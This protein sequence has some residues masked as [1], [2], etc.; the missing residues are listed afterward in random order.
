M[1]EIKKYMMEFMSAKTNKEKYDPLADY[2]KKY[3]KDFTRFKY[4]FIDDLPPQRLM[5]GDKNYYIHKCRGNYFVGVATLIDV[6]LRKGAITNPDT[7]KAA[8]DYKSYVR[9][10]DFSVFSTKDDID[11]VNKVLDSLISE[12]SKKV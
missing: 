2:H 1:L 9:E 3:L 11:K 6:A 5:P 4:E 7:V 8:N 12:L 10:R